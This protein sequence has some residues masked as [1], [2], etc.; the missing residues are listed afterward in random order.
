MLG[1]IRPKTNLCFCMDQLLLGRTFQ[2]IPFVTLGY[3]ILS[4][5]VTTAALSNKQLALYLCFDPARTIVN[6]EYWRIITNY[7]IYPSASDG[8]IFSNSVQFVNLPHFSYGI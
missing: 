5:L 8:I 6:K 1:H 2:Q 4:V 7:L 3:I